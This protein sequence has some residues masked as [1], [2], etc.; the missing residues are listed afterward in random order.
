[1]LNSQ[2]S[3]GWCAIMFLLLVWQAVYSRPPPDLAAL[4]L[5]LPRPQ[6]L[7][8]VLH[9]PPALAELRTV[10]E[11]VVI[12]AA[13]SLSS[14]AF[15]LQVGPGTGICGEGNS[16]EHGACAVMHRTNACQT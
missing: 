10:D 2:D 13:L 4:L 1:M 11:A 3:G 15:V 5:Q 16:S 9:A 8:N 14:S 12:G 7:E 6:F